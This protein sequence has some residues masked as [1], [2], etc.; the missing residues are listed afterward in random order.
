[1]F[2]AQ[3][4]RCWLQHNRVGIHLLPEDGEMV[5]AFADETEV[6]VQGMDSVSD[7]T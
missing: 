6:V 2:T 5:N 1:M 7:C 3:A 4:L